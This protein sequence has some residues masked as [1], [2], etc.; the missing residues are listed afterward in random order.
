MGATTEKKK[1]KKLQE[2]AAKEVKQVAIRVELTNKI[3][4]HGGVWT[5]T[6]IKFVCI[7]LCFFPCVC[8]ELFICTGGTTFSGFCF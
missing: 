4:T 1:K 3:A 2:K 7:C 6:Q 5:T 8:I